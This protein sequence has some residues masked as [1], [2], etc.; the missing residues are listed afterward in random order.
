LAATHD[1]GRGRR[2]SQAG[3]SAQPLR[4]DCSSGCRPQRMQRSSLRCSRCGVQRR[5][6][7]K[8]VDG[9]PLARAQVRLAKR[10][11]KEAAC[12][13]TACSCSSIFACFSCRSVRH[14]EYLSTGYAAPDD[15]IRT[16]Y[17]CIETTIS[18][19]PEVCTCACVTCLCSRADHANTCI[20]IPAELLSR[21]W[22]PPAGT[23]PGGARGDLAGRAGRL[24]VDVVS[25]GEKYCSGLEMHSA[26]QTPLRMCA[27]P[28]ACRMNLHLLVLSAVASAPLCLRV[29]RKGCTATVS[30]P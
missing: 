17:D 6:A 4:N 29:Q 16:L 8:A 3:V 21:T 27:V 19:H 10:F 30:A 15:H 20:L 9:W 7:R 13:W 22:S 23:I 11:A 28:A 2:G 12:S 5:A 18:R 14:P 24:R 26:V 1:G 25:A